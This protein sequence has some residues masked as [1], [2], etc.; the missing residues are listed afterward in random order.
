MS[1]E[2]TISCQRLFVPYLIIL[3]VVLKRS[4]KENSCSECLGKN[5]E[6]IKEGFTS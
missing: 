5:E 6:E 3:D 2:C 1:I 4:F